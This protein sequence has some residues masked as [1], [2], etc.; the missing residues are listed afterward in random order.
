MAQRNFDWLIGAFDQAPVEGNLLTN[1]GVAYPIISTAQMAQLGDNLRVER[2]IGSTYC[3]VWAGLSLLE[4]IQLVERI[5]TTEVDSSGNLP[6]GLIQNLATQGDFERDW[7]W[8]R[9]QYLTPI[10]LFGFGP[11]VQEHFQVWANAQSSGES[12][13]YHEVDCQVKRRMK[14]REV[15]IYDVQFIYPFPGPLPTAND[16][17]LVQ[18]RL[19]VGVKY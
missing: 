14:D 3:G 6:D 13:H 16:L 8:E 7:M 5:Y 1:R 4:G 10:N 18:S 11:S 17:F 9:R 12:P 19:R 15:L 2:V